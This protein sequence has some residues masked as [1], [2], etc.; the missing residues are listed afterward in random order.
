MVVSFDPDEVFLLLFKDKSRDLRE[1][2]ILGL[3]KKY[4]EKEA[5]AGMQ[6]TM[7]AT[8]SSTMLMNH[9]YAISGCEWTK[10]EKNRTVGGLGSRHSLKDIH[11]R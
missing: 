2:T 1:E 10:S 11:P 5:Q 4:R 7:M 9:Q 6:A 3:L 8:L